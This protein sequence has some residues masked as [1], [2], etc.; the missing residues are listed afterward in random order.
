MWKK[1]S[2]SDE[3]DTGHRELPVWFQWLLSMLMAH[4]RKCIPTRKVTRKYTQTRSQLLEVLGLRTE[5]LWSKDYDPVGS[6][7]QYCEEEPEV[8]LSTFSVNT[9]TLF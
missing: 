1:V 8:L 6:Q 5:C 2:F 3:P 9:S 7:S 4:E